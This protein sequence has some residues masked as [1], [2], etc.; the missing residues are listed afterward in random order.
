MKVQRPMRAAGFERLLISPAALGTIGPEWLS[1]VLTGH[2]SPPTLPAAPVSPDLSLAQPSL[3]SRP[4]MSF[5]IWRAIIRNATPLRQRK[6]R[7]TLGLHTQRHNAQG[8]AIQREHQAQLSA[9]LH[10]AAGGRRLR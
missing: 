2:T 5:E 8:D 3:R 10:D 9:D 4:A 1:P 6:L 7:V